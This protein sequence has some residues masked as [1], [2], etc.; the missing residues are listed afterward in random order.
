MTSSNIVGS[1][2]FSYEMNPDWAKLPEG[3]EMPTAAVYGD[4]QD[5]VY[6]FNRDPE[7][8]VCIFDKDGNFISA[9]GSGLITFAHSILLDK[10]DNVWLV[11]R[12]THEVHKYTGDGQH[13]MTIGQK[14]VRSDTG[15]DPDDYSSTAFQ[16]VTH[17]GPPF[18]MPA[19]IALNDAGEIFIA[20]GYA[21][22]RV[23]KFT[24]QGQ[25]IQSWGEPGDGPG[26]FRL[27][28]GIWIDRHG[29]VLVADREN[30][31]VQAFT[32]DG[33]YVTTWPSKLIGPALFYI[34]SDDIVYIPEHNGGTVQRPVPGRRNHH[35]MGIRTPPLLPRRLGRLQQRPLLRHARRVGPQPPSGQVSP[36]LGRRTEEGKGRGACGLNPPFDI[37]LA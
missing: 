23:H 9:W 7:H 13:I 31:R 34:D 10:D 35:A 22:A 18:N 12:N 6:A 33:E 16:S 8:P 27:P 11:D 26:Q 28:H 2:D 24:P 20:D 25:L 32:Q 19:G 36:A 4:S 37:L 3:W 30:D 5:R 21:N 1:G 14:G 15:V 17:G 29:Q